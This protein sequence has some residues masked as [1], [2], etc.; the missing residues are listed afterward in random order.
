MKMKEEVHN[1]KKS[2]SKMKI[3]NRKNQN[4]CGYDAC[5]SWARNVCLMGMKLMFDAHET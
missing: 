1:Y 5:V 2:S 4:L 3:I